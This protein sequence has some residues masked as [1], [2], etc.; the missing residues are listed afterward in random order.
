VFPKDDTYRELVFSKDTHVYL[1]TFIK[2]IQNSSAFF[3]TLKDISRAMTK[4]FLSIYQF[5]NNELEGLIRSEFD[6]GENIDY[7]Q[8]M[9]AKV[10]ILNSIFELLTIIK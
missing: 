9:V 4:V 2:T 1:K 5:L 6:I 10:G 8:E 3:E 7:R